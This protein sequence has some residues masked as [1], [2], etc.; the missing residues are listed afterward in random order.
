MEARDR[1]VGVSAGDA[2]PFSLS[3][4]ALPD[5]GH[6]GIHA[7]LVHVNNRYIEPIEGRDLGD[8]AAHE[9]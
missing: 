7:G 9:T 3:F 8:S 5:P 2:A 1:R 4:K 6:P